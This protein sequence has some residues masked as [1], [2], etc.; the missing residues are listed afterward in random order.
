MWAPDEDVARQV[1]KIADGRPACHRGE[2]LRRVTDI[3]IGCAALEACEA[4]AAAGF[5]FNWHESEHALNRDG[6]PY[7]LPG[8]PGVSPGAW[9]AER[10]VRRA[11][12]K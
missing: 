6:W 5:T 11:S 9:A 12:G 10:S 8:M 3:D 4:L 2:A 7:T 1:R